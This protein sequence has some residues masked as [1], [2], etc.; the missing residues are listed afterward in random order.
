MPRLVLV[1]TLALLLVACGGADSTA[2][3]AA[4]TADE[5]ETAAVLAVDGAVFTF[6][7]IEETASV[8]PRLNLAP[9]VREMQTTRDALAAEDWPECA[10]EVKTLYG[11]YMNGMIDGYLAFMADAETGATEINAARAAYISAVRLSVTLDA[12]AT[13]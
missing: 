11:Q 6:S 5:A 8:T 7:D 12:T 4:C 3:D 1:M 2:D 9:L 10:K 13:P